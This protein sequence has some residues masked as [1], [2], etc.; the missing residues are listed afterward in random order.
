TSEASASTE[1]RTRELQGR[2]VRTHGVL[3]AFARVAL[4]RDGGPAGDPEHGVDVGG[5]ETKQVVVG[6]ERARVEALDALN[7]VT[8]VG[9]QLEVARPEEILEAGDGAPRVRA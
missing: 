5:D 3:L 8:A 2:H 4:L 7:D 6:A 1:V 9:G